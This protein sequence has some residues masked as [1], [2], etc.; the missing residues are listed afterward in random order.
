MPHSSNL[1]ARLTAV[2]PALLLFASPH[3]AVAAP[4]DEFP[5]GSITFVETVPIET[6][7]DL[8]EVPD[9][10]GL[11]LDLVD[12]ARRSLDIFA[13]YVSPN[14][15]GVGRLQP[16]LAAIEGRA[17]AGVAVRLLSDR[18]FHATYPETHE[19]FTRH[20]GIDARLLDA[21][22]AWGG[23]LHAKGM[24]IDGERFFLGSQNWDWRA[25][26]HIHELGVVVAHEALAADLER[27]YDLDW[28]L[29][30]G[31]TLPPLRDQAP[32]LPEWQPV[33][34]LTLPDGRT[35]Q[36]VLA[37]S[38][39]QALPPGIPWDL[40]LLLDQIDQAQSRVR[41]QLLS[42]NPGD[43]DGGW[44]PDLD[45]ALRRAALRG[46]EVQI[47]LSDW[48]KRAYMLTHIQSLAVLPGIEIRFV[49]IPQWSGGFIP[50]A[51]TEHAKYLTC[52]DQALWLG[53][54]NGARNYF[55]QSRNISLFLR[56]EG[57]TEAA[58]AFFLRSWSSPYAETVDPC[59]R[60]TAPR[61]Q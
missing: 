11:W 55:H 14:P 54:S 26:E 17:E 41:L 1:P 61:R 36:A 43:R 52:D 9:T 34:M 10:A 58:D 42:Y 49:T 20:P 2:L 33:R 27:L 29:A 47:L 5:A 60:Y 4:A 16:V 44:W 37:A 59:G 51:R 35:C 48:A 24:I 50:F 22:A 32:N 30:G 25:L 53:T 7:L 23:V 6:D 56:G 21:E 39:P 18:K 46:C 40:P 8:P 31:E 38:P 12:G 57:C 28:A 15:D 19:R 13:F 45:A 3:G